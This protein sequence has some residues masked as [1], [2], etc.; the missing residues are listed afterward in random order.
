MM[1]PP[2]GRSII[3]PKHIFFGIYRPLLFRHPE[4]DIEHVSFTKKFDIQKCLHLS[5]KK[6]SIFYHYDYLY[7][8]SLRFP[9]ELENPPHVIPESFDEFVSFWVK[10]VPY[11]FQDL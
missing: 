4:A 9:L 2:I 3:L 5:T 8:L 6:C 1:P 11:S 7:F 10:G